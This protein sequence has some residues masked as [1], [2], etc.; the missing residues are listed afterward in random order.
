MDGKYREIENLKLEME[1]AGTKRADLELTLA[2]YTRKREQVSG[3]QK[4]L[5]EKRESLSGR[6]G[7]LDREAALLQNQMEKLEEKL[8]NQIN[9][10]WSEYEL[11]PVTAQALRKEDWTVL[12]EIRQKITGQKA[13]IRALGN[14]NV[15]AIEDYKEVSDRYEF[16]KTQHDDLI[17]AE[18]TLKKIIEEL[19]QGMRRQFEEKF[20]EIRHEF[21][22]VF[23]E[24]FGGGHGVLELLEGE[25]IPGSRNPDY[26]PTAGQ[27]AG[28]T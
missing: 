16:M 5:F 2:E 7:E 20:Q 15:N 22:K 24:L 21:D 17:L 10:M 28:R 14:V 26:F 9:Y 13:A 6:A 23:R 1:T 18:E 11:T 4:G 3:Q 27:E 19:D 12:S 8:E 25:D